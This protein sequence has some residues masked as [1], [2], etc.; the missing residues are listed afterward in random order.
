MS[1]SARDPRVLTRED[2][3]DTIADLKSDLRDDLRRITEHLADLNGRTRKGEIADAEVRLQ[4]GYLQA[5]LAAHEEHA[6]AARPGPVTAEASAPVAYALSPKAQA[7]LVGSAV[8]VL[9]VLFKLMG[10]VTSV[11]GAKALDLLVKK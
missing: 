2:F 10:A 5:Q 7:A 11:V 4:I 3:A 9:T 6:A 1:P 8:L